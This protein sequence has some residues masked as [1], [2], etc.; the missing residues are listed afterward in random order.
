MKRNCRRTDEERAVHERACKLR[1]M[2]DEQ[3]CAAMDR[4][5]ATQQE[6]VERF[7]HA[8]TMR[9]ESGT[10]LSDATIRKIR[11]IAV[12]KGFIFVTGYER[13]M[14]S[15]RGAQNKALGAAFEKLISAGCDFYREQGIADIEKTPEPMQPIKELG[16]G[17]FI[18]HYLT[19]AQAD[20][21]G[22]MMGGRAICIEAK[23]TT[24]GKLEQD[25]VTPE[26]AACLTRAHNYGAYAFVL[27]SF[28]PLD[29]YRVPWPVWADM[30]NR[31]GHKYI[32]PKEAAPYKVRIGPRGALLFLE[33]LEDN[34]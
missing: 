32:T 6:T 13:S 14:R 23:H 24:T 16:H 34:R 15:Y 10:R 27:A 33:G 20:F 7:L 19:T 26:Q 31:Y 1:R 17:R 28:G 9:S 4:G 18:A 11:G 30:K 22:Y 8:L 12:E 21:K 5:N 2:T 3:L 25:R 29:I